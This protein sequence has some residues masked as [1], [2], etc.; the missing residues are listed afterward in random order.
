MKLKTCP[1][2][3]QDKPMQ[4]YR[5]PQRHKLAWAKSCASCRPKPKPPAKATLKNLSTRVAKGEMTAFE[6][7]LIK[8]NRKIAAEIKQGFASRKRWLRTWRRELD[9]VLSPLTREMK[10][11]KAALRYHGGVVREFYVAYEALVF[12]EINRIRMK[13][14]LA[15]ASP[16]PVPTY[17]DYTHTKTYYTSLLDESTVPRARAL[18]AAVPIEIREK[19]RIPLLIA[20]R[21]SGQLTTNTGESK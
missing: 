12:G 17:P 19:L 1:S 4:A 10:K 16:H 2:C 6:L 21:E 3:G 5:M 15:P 18:W 20:E 11:I 7:S 13:H 9:E 14:E 8:D